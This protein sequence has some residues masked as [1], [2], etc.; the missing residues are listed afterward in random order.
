[1]TG[2]EAEERKRQLRGLLLLAAAAL[3]FMVARSKDV[4]HPGWWR[5]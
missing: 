5:W 3:A 4:F 1:M 2:P